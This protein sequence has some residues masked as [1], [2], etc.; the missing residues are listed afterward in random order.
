[1]TPRLYKEGDELLGERIAAQARE[2]TPRRLIHLTG[3]HRGVA[4]KLKGSAYCVI[5]VPLVSVHQ[6]RERS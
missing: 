1:M 3:S 2:A 4:F 6:K 5:E